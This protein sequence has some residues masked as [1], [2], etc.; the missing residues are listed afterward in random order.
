MTSSFLPY[1]L[2]PTSNNLALNTRVRATSNNLPPTAFGEGSEFSFGLLTSTLMLVV[3]RLCRTLG[4]RRTTAPVQSLRNIGS[5]KSW[6]HIVMVSPGI[7]PCLRRESRTELRPA[8]KTQAKNRE[9][10]RP[11]TPLAEKG[12]LAHKSE[13][14]IV[15][16]GG[17]HLWPNMVH[18]EAQN[19]HPLDPMWALKPRLPTNT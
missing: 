6:L 2:L 14:R 16:N 12:Y 7:G 5:P 4:A 15:A 11:G 19:E 18:S 3:G 1:N 10:E 8:S 17:N 13:K 9:R